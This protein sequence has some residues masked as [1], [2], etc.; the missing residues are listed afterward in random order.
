MKTKLLNSVCTKFTK[1]ILLFLTVLLGSV[2]YWQAMAQQ[3]CIPEYIGSGCA[4]DMM[5]V[6]VTLEG[7]ST[8][9]NND[10]ECSV[11]AYGDFTDLPPADLVPQTSYILSVEVAADP[12]YL[13]VRAWIDYN[14][15]GEFT[16]DEEI[17]NTQGDGLEEGGSSFEFT[18]PEDAEEGEL[19]M[20]IRMIA[21]GGEDNISPCEDAVGGETEDYNIQIIPLEACAEADAGEIVGQENL[22]VCSGI[23]F[24]L[25]VEGQ[26]ISALGLNR[27]WQSSPAGED[28]WTNLEISY[29]TLEMEEGI[30]QDT[31]FRYYVSCEN[32]HED[33]SNVISVNLNPDPTA[34]YCTPETDSPSYI[35]EFS[36]QN[37]IENIDNEIES[38]ENGY[39]DFTDMIVTQSRNES[40]DFSALS[41]NSMLGMKIWVDWNQDGEFSDEEIVYQT[42]GYQENPTGSF[43]VPDEALDGP[44]RMR[45]GMSVSLVDGPTEACAEEISSSYHDYTFEV[46]VLDSCSEAIAGNIVGDSELEICAGSAF[47]LKVENQT[48]PA[49]GL[50]RSWQFSPSEENEWTDL[51]ISSSMLNVGEDFV[52]EA[53]DFRY[54][55]VCENGQEDSSEVISVHPKDDNPEDCYCEP[56][57]KFEAAGYFSLIESIGANNDLYYMGI[58]ADSGEYVDHTELIIESMPGQEFEINTQYSSSVSNHTIGIWVDWNQNGYFGDEEEEQ[59]FLNHTSSGNVQTT[60]LEVPGD[61]EYG[62]YRLRIRGARTNHVSDGDSFACNEANYGSAIDFTI[63]ITDGSITCTDP[64]E[65]SVDN[66]TEDSVEVHWTAQGDENQWEVLFGVQGFDVNTE[67]EVRMADSTTIVLENLNANTD[68]DVYVQALCDEDISSNWVGPESFTTQNMSVNEIEFENFKFYPNPVEN[69]L[70]IQAQNPIEQITIYNL[71]GQEITETTPKKYQTQIKTNHWSAGVY[72]MKVKIKEVDKIY[73]IIKK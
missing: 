67:G 1:K 46:E 2:F 15:D 30:D 49:D 42:L 34:C 4:N 20:R 24:V 44:T 14:N 12:S 39:Q 40:I 13:N 64:S 18:V 48:N 23:P 58:L 9:I 11:D 26:S 16:E 6:N 25:E 28:D 71:L 3:Y 31:D 70:N 29:S 55:V 60:T 66:I 41:N 8:S 53:M 37:G 61:I 35:T 22:E 72:L 10:S 36:T 73:K 57:Y 7:E 50:I 56:S 47:S 62:T 17:V 19:R 21:F 51:D 63:L 27:T 32:G 54:H 5:I 52:F 43:L 59:I 45:V 33:Y 38:A 65:L 69:I 68:Y